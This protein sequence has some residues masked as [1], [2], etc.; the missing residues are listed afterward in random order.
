MHAARSILLSNTRKRA[1][2]VK[3]TF[4]TDD[5]LILERQKNSVKLLSIEMYVSVQSISKNQV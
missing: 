5:G 3:R 1:K 4:S 2:T